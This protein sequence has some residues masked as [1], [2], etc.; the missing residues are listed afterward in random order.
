M[1]KPLHLFVGKSAS[2]KSSVAIMFEQEK[3]YM[4]VQSCTTRPKRYQGEP[5]HTFLTNEEFNNLGE[6]VAYTEYDGYRYGTTAQQLDESDIYVVDIPGVETLLERYS[7]ERQINIFYFD[8][9]V[10]TRIMRMLNRHD[11][12]LAIIKRLLQDEQD[13][14]W[15]KLRALTLYAYY[16]HKNVQLYKINANDDMETVFEQILCYINQ[17]EE[18]E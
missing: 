10:H 6:L 8:S 7:T 9:T 4:Q 14:W 2:G 17:N 12:D 16:K 11:S 18:L 15:T 5:G 3:N 13:N 1:N